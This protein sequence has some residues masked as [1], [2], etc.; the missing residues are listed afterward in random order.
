MSV[1]RNKSKTVLTDQILSR[2]RPR[3]DG[4]FYTL[5]DAE[6]PNLRVTVRV[7]GDGK[8]LI[9]FTA[10]KD[11]RTYR[12]GT[13]PETL[14]DDARDKAKDPNI[15]ARLRVRPHRLNRISGPL[16]KRLVNETNI[17]AILEG[18]GSFQA[19]HPSIP[20]FAVQRTTRV[21]YSFKCKECVVRL[22]DENS[23]FRTVEEHAAALWRIYDAWKYHKRGDLRL[24][25]ETSLTALRSKS[26]FPSW[27]QGT[28]T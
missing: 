22:G 15:A 13:Y 1:T 9:S 4:G 14:L 2:L 25:L 17:D 8:A 16:P 5:E 20:F 7:G 24:L 27:A 19:S 18:I 21:T 12:L 11:K 10:R 26:S 23:D 28:T 3:L 6:C